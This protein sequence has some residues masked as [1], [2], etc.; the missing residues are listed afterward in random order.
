M[1]SAFSEECFLE[2]ERSSNHLH[3]KS[4]VEHPPNPINARGALA[5]KEDLASQEIRK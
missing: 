3:F 4:V 1:S 2:R 5:G